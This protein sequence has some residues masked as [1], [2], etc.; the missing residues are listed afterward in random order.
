MYNPTGTSASLGIQ[1][2]RTFF[3]GKSVKEYNSYDR[4]QTQI[5]ITTFYRQILEMIVQVRQW[6][7]L[8]GMETQS[9]STIF[10]II[11]SITS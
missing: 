3:C 1:N 4:T 8:L 7:S 9:L 5:E 11:K 10:I 6:H 2:M